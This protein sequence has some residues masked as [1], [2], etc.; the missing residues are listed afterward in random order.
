MGKAVNMQQEEARRAVLARVLGCDEAEVPEEVIFAM[1][2]GGESQFDHE[3][4]ECERSA[5]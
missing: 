4:G 5:A 3:R 2:G 1:P